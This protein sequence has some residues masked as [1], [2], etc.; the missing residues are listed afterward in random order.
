MY[1]RE[2]GKVKKALLSVKSED[3]P[4][5]SKGGL[6]VPLPV[7]TYRIIYSFCRAYFVS[8]FA[9]HPETL[10]KTLPSFQGKSVP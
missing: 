10:K 4:L 3:G 8:L 6:D 2:I 9:M 7:P 5:F 1:E